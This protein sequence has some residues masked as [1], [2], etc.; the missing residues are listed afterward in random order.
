MVVGKDR[1]EKRR[2]NTERMHSCTQ[3]PSSGSPRT[4]APKTNL[5]IISALRRTCALLWRASDLLEYS[6]PVL[7][8]VPSTP[9]RGALA[10][11]P[12][13]HHKD[14]PRCP[15]S[16]GH[17]NERSNLSRLYSPLRVQTVLTSCLRVMSDSTQLPP[18]LTMR[19][20]TWCPRFEHDTLTAPRFGCEL[21]VLGWCPPV[22]S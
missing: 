4:A 3:N 17:I 5:S 16:V 2:S 22:E 14:G 21:P 1:K 20:G 11:L 6:Q 19:A 13:L 8:L 12:L 10:V 9:R 15:T 7:G 18:L